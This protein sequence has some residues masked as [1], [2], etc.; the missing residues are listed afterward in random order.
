MQIVLL[1]GFDTEEAI[2]SNSNKISPVRSVYDVNEEGEVI[3]ETN[4][5][6]RMESPKRQNSN[7]EPVMNTGPIAVQL[8]QMKSFATI[9]NSPVKKIQSLKVSFKEMTNPDR[10]DNC[11]FVLPVA[12]IHAVKTKY[13]NSL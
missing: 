8:P 2:W 7:S 13:E 9:V 4:A 6:N 1:L 5:D 10:V 12:A 11:D 3:R